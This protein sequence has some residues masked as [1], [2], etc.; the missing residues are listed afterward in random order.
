VLDTAG[1]VIGVVVAKIRG[2]EGLS[3]CIPPEDLRQALERLNESGD[4][5][6]AKV[7]SRH[8]VELAYL[9]LGAGAFI[10]SHWLNEHVKAMRD[11]RSKERQAEITPRLKEVHSYLSTNLDRALKTIAKDTSVPN[12]SRKYFSELSR[13]CETIRRAVESPRPPA[14]ALENRLKDLSNTRDKQMLTLLEH[15]ELPYEL[16]IDCPFGYS[17]EFKKVDAPNEP[18][19]FQ[20]KSLL[21]IPDKG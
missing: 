12:E 3:F 14:N 16:S 4:D 19:G 13:T 17:V 9:R 6:R 11:G 8:R 1:Q 5:V 20:L 21:R 15:L 7:G 10:Y 2:K 18:N